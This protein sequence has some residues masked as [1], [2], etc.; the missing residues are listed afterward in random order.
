MNRKNVLQKLATLAVGGIM[1]L[2]MFACSNTGGGSSETTISDSDAISMTEYSTPVSLLYW[3][4]EEY[5]SADPD[6]LV[7][8]YLMGGETRTDKGMP[9]TVEYTFGNLDGRAVVEEKLEVSSKSDFSSIEQTLYFAPRRSQVEIYNLKT[10]ATYYYRVVVKLDNGE[11]H[12]KANSF[13]TKNSLRFISLDGACNVRDIGGWTTENGQTVKQG[14]LYRGSEIDGGKNVGHVDF[15][16]TKK[17]V[18]QLRALGIKTDFDLRSEENKVGEY[19]ILGQDVTR[20]FY[21]APQYQSFFN[22]N[23]KEAVRKIFSDLAKPDAYPVYLHCTHGV[24]RAGSTALLI[25][26]LLGVSKADLI[27][28]Y[29]LSAFY[30]NY[31]Q[32]NRNIYTGGNVLTMIEQLEAFDGETLAEK[33]ENFLLSVGVTAEEIASIRSIF[34]EKN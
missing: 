20:T 12:I 21:N 26:S 8:H 25:E 11:M 16:L 7:T 4:V 14:L 3:N 6:Q 13:E 28:D 15:C 2:S 23:N 34:L 24:D 22:A 10:G 17:G 18:E 9:V 27:R 32:V 5:L 19:S 31:A 1:A 33:T 29:E 30:Y